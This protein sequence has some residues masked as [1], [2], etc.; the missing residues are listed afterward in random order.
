MADIS[1]MIEPVQAKFPEFLGQFSCN[2]L[3]ISTID[4]SPAESGCFN[5]LAVVLR[6]GDRK[7]VFTGKENSVL[8]KIQTAICALHAALGLEHPQ[9]RDPDT[10]KVFWAPRTIIYPMEIADLMDMIKTGHTN[11]VSDNLAGVCGDIVILTSAWESNIALKLMSYEEALATDPIIASWISF[12]QNAALGSHTYILED[13]PRLIAVSG[14]HADEGGGI[15]EGMHPQG[16]ISIENSRIR[17]RSGRAG[18][19]DRGSGVGSTSS[20]LGLS[21]Q[22]QCLPT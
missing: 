3:L 10:G 15:L 17:G 18:G 14:P 5:P 9:E 6:P 2:G 4:L 21:T 1:S 8:T 19:L 12:A 16:C 20:A 11:F 22:R 13:G 7:A